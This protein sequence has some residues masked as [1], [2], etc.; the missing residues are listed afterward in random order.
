M[1]FPDLITVARGEENTA[2]PGLDLE[3]DL[4]SSKQHRLVCERDSVLENC[5]LLQ[6]GE[7]WASFV[8]GCSVPPSS[9]FS[10]G[11]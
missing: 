4:A 10:C 8:N 3:W 11:D 7:G 9:S 6:K 2:W 5:V 1:L